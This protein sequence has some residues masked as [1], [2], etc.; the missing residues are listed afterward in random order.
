MDLKNAAA[1]CV[2]SLF[3][4]TLVVLIARSL[5]SQA[6]SRLEPRLASIVEEL[7]AIREQGRITPAAEIGRANEPAGDRLMIYF[8]HA[9]QRCASCEAVE[10][11]MEELLKTDFAPQ[12]SRGEIAWKSLDYEKPTSAD[13][14]RKFKVGG[15]VVVLAKMKDNQLLDCWRALGKVM[16]LTGDKPALAAYLRNEI[17]QMLP[18]TRQAASAPPESGR[19]W[20]PIG[21]AKA[22]AGVAPTE[23]PSVPVPEAKTSD[24]T[25]PKDPPAIPLS[26]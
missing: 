17:R 14:L 19:S 3:S 12:V 23:L 11:T 9:T 8:F 20:K 25:D 2:V 10:S 15:I 6:A 4:A 7:R 5:D 21:E 13:L 26:K 1:V 18:D 24:P 16:A 22:A